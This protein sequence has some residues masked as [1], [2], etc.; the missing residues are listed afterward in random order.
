MAAAFSLREASEHRQTSEGC[1]IVGDVKGIAFLEILL[2]LRAKRRGAFLGVKLREA[3][4]LAS[5]QRVH[6]F[7]GL[8]MKSKAIAGTFVNSAICLV[9]AA[10]QDVDGKLTETAVA[11]ASGR[12]EPQATCMLADA[13]G[14]WSCPD[15]KL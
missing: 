13:A 11:D 5:P 2:K 14:G 4:D 8:E 1:A 12:L 10:L 15:P 9:E 6:S 3:L 7:V